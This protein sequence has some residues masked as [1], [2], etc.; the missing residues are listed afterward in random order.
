MLAGDKPMKD[1]LLVFPC[2]PRLSAAD[3]DKLRHHLAELLDHVADYETWPLERRMD[4]MRRAKQGPI[5]DLPANL[6]HFR[7]RR[8]EV[9]AEYD[10]RRLIASLMRRRG[11]VR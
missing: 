8:A 9:F 1:E 3:V 10:A 2:G 4:V 11:E 5:T 7:E 6:A